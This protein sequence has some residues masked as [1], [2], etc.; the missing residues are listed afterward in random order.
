MEKANLEQR[1]PCGG[2]E[3]LMNAGE[4]SGHAVQRP[5]RQGEGVF[6]I[7]FVARNADGGRVFFDTDQ[8]TSVTVGDLTIPFAP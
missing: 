6:T 1:F 8:I 2:E 4:R 3:G 7:S 5:Q